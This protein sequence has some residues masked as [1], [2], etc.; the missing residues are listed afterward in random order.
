MYIYV[1]IY[2][3][4]YICMYIYVCITDETYNMGTAHYICVISVCTLYH[5]IVI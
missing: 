1:C 5:D 3:Y 4:V 2:T